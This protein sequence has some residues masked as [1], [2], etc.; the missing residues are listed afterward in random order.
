MVTPALAF[1]ALIDTWGLIY[2]NKDAS[3]TDLPLVVDTRVATDLPHNCAICA[4]QG[5]VEMQVHG[6][7]MRKVGAVSGVAIHGSTFHMDFAPVRAEQGPFENCAAHWR[8]FW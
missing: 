6:R 7:I 8:V 4:R 5:E 1:T 3:F 2:D